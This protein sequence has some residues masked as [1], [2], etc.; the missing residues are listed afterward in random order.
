MHAVNQRTSKFAQLPIATYTSISRIRLRLELVECDKW[1]RERERESRERGSRESVGN[2]RK[3][4]ERKRWR[5]NGR[6]RERLCRIP[7]WFRSTLLPQTDIFTVWMN[8]N[9]CVCTLL[10]PTRIHVRCRRES[11]FAAFT[12]YSVH[13]VHSV[14]VY[15]AVRHTLNAMCIE[16]YLCF[17]TLEKCQRGVLIHIEK[18]FADD[19]YIR[20]GG[21]VLNGAA[22]HQ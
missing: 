5:A 18:C 6:E 3:K 10:V 19:K 8:L 13:T 4:E 2:W 20:M 15:G 1:H 22:R 11:V 7:I 16:S 21:Y 17:G 9:F 14:S 12:L